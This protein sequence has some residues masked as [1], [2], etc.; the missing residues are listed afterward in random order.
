MGNWTSRK[1][2]T[3]KIAKGASYKQTDT[4]TYGGKGYTYSSS[5]G[6]KA[7]RTTFSTS[8]DGTKMTT[9]VR[10]GN[11]MY[12]RTTKTI[13]SSKVKRPRKIRVKKGDT[14]V[15]FVL[16]FIITIIALML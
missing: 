11:G 15:L 12:M 13:S 3:T 1:T 7:G 14:S 16:I 9:T 6:S 2:R 8:K 5:I 10:N 4:Y